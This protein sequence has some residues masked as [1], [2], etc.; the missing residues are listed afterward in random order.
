MSLDL[1]LEITLKC[2][3]CGNE[4]PG[5]GRELWTRNITHNVSGMWVKAGVYEAF[6]KSEGHKA[7]EYI[8]ALENGIADFKANFP[9][10]E[11]LNSKNGWGLAEHALLFLEDALAEFKANPEATIRVSA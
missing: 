7:S 8:S 2:P 9:E 3:H 10:Y 6:Y 4:L 1:S 5:G 11:K